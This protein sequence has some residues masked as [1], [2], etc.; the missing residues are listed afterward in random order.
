MKKFSLLAF[1]FLFASI[2]SMSVIAGAY[3]PQ[4]TIKSI[5]A[6]A[7]GGFDVNTNE[8]V[9]AACTNN[10]QFFRVQ[11]GQH[12]MTAEGVKTALSVA[13]TAFGTGKAIVTFVDTSSVYCH[14]SLVQIESS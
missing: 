13:L 11:S 12:G 2:T 10:G 7:S 14:A 8:V 9:N 5:R 1:L 6:L 3:S 4:V